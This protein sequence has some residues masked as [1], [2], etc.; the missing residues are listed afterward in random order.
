MVAKKSS[1]SDIWFV[2]KLATYATLLSIAA[3]AGCTN[4]EIED[5]SLQYNQAVGSLGNRLLLLNAVRAAQDYPMQFSKLA[6]YTGQGRGKGSLGVELP[7]GVNK[8]GSGPLSPDLLTGSLK[9][10]IELNSGV[11]SFQLVDL[12]TAEAQRALRTQPGTAEYEYYLTQ[13]WPPRIVTTI[14][15]EM[16]AVRVELVDIMSK[17]YLNR[18]KADASQ[19]H[20]SMYN[21]FS[22]YQAEVKQTP[23]SI[24]NL[25]SK[26]YEHKGVNYI[27]FFNR[28]LDRCR[29]IG[30]QVLFDAFNVSGGGFDLLIP[31]EDE[32]A[33][34]G[35]SNKKQLNYTVDVNVNVAEVKQPK[36]K[37][38][39]EIP[40]LFEDK[41]VASVYKDM[42]KPNAPQTE[43]GGAKKQKQRKRG[44]FEL[45]FRS[46]ERMSDF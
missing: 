10:T 28:P 23:D 21:S 5:H 37:I 7:F 12:N 13:G 44:A 1:A 22:V 32:S 35:E 33:S 26:P 43:T 24:K 15:V 31:T 6:S 9:P 18:C 39:R 36:A 3:L 45:V 30:F 8:I 16:I 17:K 29:F 41:D 19:R 25:G 38:K 40:V 42:D 4:Y 11:N 20:C 2:R 27:T 46:P 14:M 34:D